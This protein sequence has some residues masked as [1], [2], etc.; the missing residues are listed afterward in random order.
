M[1]QRPS[2]ARADLTEELATLDRRR[3]S[4][5]PVPDVLVA[6][7][8]SEPARRA[9]TDR[10]D[11]EP[12][13]SWACSAIDICRDGMAL[14]LPGAVAPGDELFLTFRLDEQT[15]FSRVPGIVV[16]TQLGFGLGAVRF[17]SWTDSE[18]R[19]LERYLAG[20]G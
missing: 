2:R 12:A 20:R 14:A 9:P 19:S 3:D 17:Q 15:S 4:R 5:V 8:A 10:G 13:P 1:H 6:V 11:A 18:R 7:E 16:R